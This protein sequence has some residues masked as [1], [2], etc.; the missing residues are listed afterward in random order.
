MIRT[1][2]FKTIFIRVLVTLSLTSEYNKYTNTIFTVK[3]WILL[4]SFYSSTWNFLW[5]CNNPR[6]KIQT[7]TENN[8]RMK[9]RSLLMNANQHKQRRTLKN[10]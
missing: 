1:A 10:I 8:Q 2:F 9:F 6:K 4:S 3:S 5:S 7:T